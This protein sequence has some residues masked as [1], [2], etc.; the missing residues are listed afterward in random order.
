MSRPV[1]LDLGRPRTLY[2]RLVLGSCPGGRVAQRES[3]RFTREG[4]QVQSLSRPPSNLHRISA[5]LSRDLAFAALLGRDVG[6]EGAFPD[7]LAGPCPSAGDT[8]VA[9]GRG[10]SLLR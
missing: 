8:G 7:R 9:A 4:S 5:F 3:I 2:R 10:G 6:T 1:A